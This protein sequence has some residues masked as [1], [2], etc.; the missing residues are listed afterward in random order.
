MRSTDEQL[1][2]VL[3]RADTVRERRAIRKKLHASIMASC[4]CV[5][6]LV[7]VGTS[8]PRVT[9]VA[10]GPAMQQYGSLLL[11]APYMGYIVV[12][13]LALALGVCVTLLCTQWRELRR[14]ERD[15]K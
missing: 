13:V 15:R 10:Q 11:A 12:G 7:A 5:A 8:L 4:V 6:L 14:K 3:R 9:V 1:H 2:E